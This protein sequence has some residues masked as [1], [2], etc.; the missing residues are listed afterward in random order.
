MKLPM[1]LIAL[2]I[3]SFGIG[4]TEFVIMGLLPDVA[5]DL[6]VTIPAA[7]LLIGGYALGVTFGSP[8]MAALLSGLSRKRAL[9]L[10]VGLFIL[11]NF[12][13]A[14]APSYRLLMAARLLTALCH[15]TFF[16]I[17][18][19]V[20]SSLVPPKQ[21]SQAV[22]IM[23]SGLTLANVLGVPLGTALGQ[24]AGWRASFWAIV[25][26]GI[27]AAFAIMRWLPASPPQ[28]GIRLSQEIRVLA[29]PAVLLPMLVSTLLSASLFATFTYVTPL[30]ET[31]AGISSHGVTTVLL[32]FGVGITI[33]NL[34]GGRLADWRQLTA[35]I[36]LTGT[37]VLML[38]VLGLAITTPVGAAAAITGWGLVHFASGAPLQMRVVDGAA[39]APNLASSLN[40]SAF[41]L[42]NALGAWLGGS[43]IAAGMSYAQLPTISAILAASALIVLML[44]A[45][46]SR[47]RL[48]LAGSAA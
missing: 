32:L 31:V 19:V 7:G 3:A 16:G 25:P 13:C 29:K 10:L 37:L 6:D 20:A 35:L 18:A 41:N 43:A 12:L 5:R 14:I 4:T 36:G 34:L 47:R 2:A 44:D 11:G 22:S 9:L 39:E 21:R 28:R 17:G 46:L 33:G 15:G 38:L 8:V 24:W 45:V 26:I 30:L 1:S 23:F 40:Q 48:S 27:L 42:G